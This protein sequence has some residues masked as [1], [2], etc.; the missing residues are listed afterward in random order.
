MGG[1]KS[2]PEKRKSQENT[3]GEYKEIHLSTADVNQLL[4][5]LAPMSEQKVVPVVPNCKFKKEVKPLWDARGQVFKLAFQRGIFEPISRVIH[6]PMP[7]TTKAREAMKSELENANVDF[8]QTR[9]VKAHNLA[10]EHFPE[11][12]SRIIAD[13]SF[14]H[15]E[16]STTSQAL[17]NQSESTHSTM[18]KNN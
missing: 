11:V 13:Y 18:R 15:R 10:Q 4:S 9:W 14:Y 2:N 3:Q 12:V 1:E 5:Q 6:G 16:Q 17:E 7:V 8:F